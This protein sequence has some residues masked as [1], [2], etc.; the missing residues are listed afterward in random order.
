MANLIKSR[1]K[2]KQK[3]EEEEDLKKQNSTDYEY[4]K[5]LSQKE[6]I[7]YLKDRNNKNKYL[8]KQYSIDYEYIKNEYIK[9]PPQDEGLKFCGFNSEEQSLL[10]DFINNV[11]NSLSNGNNERYDNNSSFSNK[12]NDKSILNSSISTIQAKTKIK[13]TETNDSDELVNYSDTLYKQIKQLKIKKIKDKIKNDTKFDHTTIS[14]MF[15]PKNIVERI[16]PKTPWQQV[17]YSI[18]NNNRNLQKGGEKMFY[19]LYSNNNRGLKK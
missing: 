7:K 6:Y 9:V 17:M 12:D 16:K 18:K 3:E 2:D 10:E 14:K 5:K 11:N 8:Q 13:K 19:N 15:A 4:I 1:F